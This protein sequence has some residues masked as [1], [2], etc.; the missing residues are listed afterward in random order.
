[1]ALDDWEA[2][3]RQLSTPR[4]ALLAAQDLDMSFGKENSKTL[5][6][7]WR[8]PDTLAAALKRDGGATSPLG[9][10][11]AD[12][13]EV[14]AA[15]ALLQEKL[16]AA[17]RGDRVDDEGAGAAPPRPPAR[18]PRPPSETP[19][20]TPPRS[21]Q[22]PE[23]VGPDADDVLA[24]LDAWR[25]RDPAPVTPRRALAAADGVDAILDAPPAYVDVKA[26]LDA[27][28]LRVEDV[29]RRI[30]EDAAEVEATIASLSD[31]REGRDS[32]MAALR[33]RLAVEFESAG[34]AEAEERDWGARANAAFDLREAST[35]RDDAGATL[36]SARGAAS[37][38]EALM[39]DKVEARAA[40][41][42]QENEG[43]F[44]ELDASGSA[45]RF[46]A[47][48]EMRRLEESLAALRAATAAEDSPP[49]SN[50]PFQEAED[51]A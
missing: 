1:M 19:S 37:R 23:G 20:E 26:E 5:T 33:A 47:D 38:V 27:A 2:M 29:E 40:A 34:P 28:A 18:S 32:E 45:L 42:A 8:A 30:D 12:E 3:R 46:A 13:R 36:D 21:P 15:L 24:Q 49:N 41:E 9:A 10:G 48:L 6:P 39:R 22:R 44:G 4:R 7:S 43:T 14:A 31:W 25:A 16:R 17:A 11:V 35:L 50:A 51:A